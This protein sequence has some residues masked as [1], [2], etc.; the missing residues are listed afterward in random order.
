MRDDFSLQTLD[1]LAK[2]VGIR[3]SNPGCRK[4]TT[5]PRSESTKII[6]IGVGAHITAAA[7][8]GPR[9]DPDLSSEK[10]KSPNNGIW[11]CQNCAK[12]VDNDPDRYPVDIL[13]RWKQ[14]AEN[15][16]LSE[17]EGGET[18]R[19]QTQDDLIDLEISYVRIRMESRHHDYV[20]EIKVQNLGNEIIRLY[21]IDL[22]FPAR[23]VEKSKVTAFLVADRTDHQTCFFRSIRHGEDDA[24]YPGDTKEVMSFPYYM[25]NDIYSHRGRLFEQPVRATFY[26]KGFQPLTLEKDF[27]ELQFF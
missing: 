12:L 3:C 8:G 11:L 15:A 25:D 19:R 17:I 27:G 2:R 26:R 1:I 4:L 5:G 10:R 22:E 14:F 21:H 16:A 24:I 9:F 18:S 20:L 6:N 13:Q 7:P 23:V